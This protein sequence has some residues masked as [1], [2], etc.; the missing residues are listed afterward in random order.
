MKNLVKCINC[1]YLG[2]GFTINDSWPHCSIKHARS[3][4]NEVSIK[5]PEITLEEAYKDRECI[6]Y[7]YERKE[8]K[9]EAYHPNQKEYNDGMIAAMLFREY[10][11]KRNSSLLQKFLSKENLTKE[12]FD[13]IMQR[14]I[15]MDENDI[16]ICRV[17]NGVV[18]NDIDFVTFCYRL[19][20]W[21]V[22]KNINGKIKSILDNLISTLAVKKES[23]K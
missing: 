19:R 4:G 6:D 20:Q 10:I 2:I 18:I 5:Q 1:G 9:E 23:V 8:D 3:L 17:V 7:V 13:I 11:E 14:A 16:R 12:E 21:A 15:K 22:S